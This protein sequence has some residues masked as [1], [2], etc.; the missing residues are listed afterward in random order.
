MN[1]FKLARPD[2]AH[3]IINNL[4]KLVIV[5]LRVPIYVLE[6]KGPLKLGQSGLQLRT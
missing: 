5:T 4:K 2:T 6:E 3:I 1:H